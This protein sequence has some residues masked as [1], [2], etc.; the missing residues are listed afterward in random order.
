LVSRV[1]EGNTILTNNKNEVRNELA[2]H[3]ETL[4]QATE[5]LN[6]KLDS[7]IVAATEMTRDVAR[8]LGA[9]ASEIE[10]DIQE[11]R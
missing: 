10:K 7:S 1:Q 9:R 5:R 3:K 6:K 11:V 4:N 2:S 8:S